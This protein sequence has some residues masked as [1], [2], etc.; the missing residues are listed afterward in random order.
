MGKGLAGNGTGRVG[1]RTKGS[2]LMILKTPGVPIPCIINIIMLCK[3][4]S[5]LEHDAQKGP[6]VFLPLAQ[7]A[8]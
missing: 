7:H 8:G 1:P 2:G 5:T 6:Q 3:N 4:S